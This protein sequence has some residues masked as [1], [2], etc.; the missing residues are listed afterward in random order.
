MSDTVIGDLFVRMGLDMTA[1]DKT[2]SSA[3]KKMDRFGT[4]MFFLGSRITA[5]V[6]VPITG[7]I[8]AVAKFGLDFDKAMSESVA[9]MG[10]VSDDLRAQME[11]TAKTVS[12]TT[13]FSSEEA[14]KGFY[15]LASAGLDAQTA[16][17]ALPV[18]A[19]FA[20]AGV[21]D[22]AK[23]TEFLAGAQASMST[24]FETSNQKVAD[25]AHIAD[26]LTAANN[27][28]LGTVQDFAEA[29]TTKAG[30]ALR[31]TNK[32]VEEGVAVLAVYAEQNIKGAAAGQQLW[33]VIRDL[34]VQAIK[35]AKAFHDAGIAVFDEYGNMRNLADIIG[36]VERATAKMSD[37]QKTQLMISLGIPARSQAAMKALIGY[38][39]AIRDNEAALKQAAGTTQEVADNQM[40]ALANQAAA[41]AHS[42]ENTAIDIFKSFIPV[43]QNYVIPLVKAAG[44][45]FKSFGRFIGELPEPVK[46]LGLAL[47]GVVAGIGPFVAFFGSMTL[48]TSVSMRGIGTLIGGLGELSKIIGFT[49]GVSLTLQRM[50]QIMPAEMAV[51]AAAAY[52]SAKAMGVRGF[53]LNRAATEAANFAGWEGKVTGSLLKQA[54]AQLVANGAVEGGLTMFGKMGIAAAALAGA[55]LLVQSYTHD[56]GE[57]AKWMLIPGYAQIQQLKDLINYLSTYD[58]VIGDVARILRDTFIIVL[59]ATEKELSKLSNAFH[60][61]FDALAPMAKAAFEAM[62]KAIIDELVEIVSAIPGAENIPMF[63][64]ML[65]ALPALKKSLHETANEMDRIAGFGTF[66][67]TTRP[68]IAALSSTLTGG[69]VPQPSVRVSGPTPFQFQSPTPPPTSFKGQGVEPPDPGKLTAVQR[70]AKDLADQ[71]TQN[72]KKLQELKLAWD[73]L[74]ETQKHDPEVLSAVWKSYDQLRQSTGAVVPELDKVFAAEED[75]QAVAAM[76]PE[77]YN[78]WAVVWSDAAVDMVD[79]AG[80]VYTALANIKDKASLD[81]FWKKNQ[82]SVQ[83]LLPFYDQL[84]PLMK[85]IVDRYQAWALGIQKASGALDAMKGKVSESVS[86]LVDVSAAKLA[87]L[88]DEIGLATKSGVDKEISTVRKGLH[89]QEVARDKSYNEQL[90]KIAAF[91]GD[92]TYVNAELAKLA[93]VKDTNEKISAADERLAAIRL[94][95]SLGVNKEIIKSFDNMTTQQIWDVDQQQAAWDKL[96]HTFTSWNNAIKNAGD[97]FSTLGLGDAAEALKGIGAGLDEVQQG[98]EAIYNADNLGATISGWI[99]LANGAVKAFKSVMDVGSKA[100]RVA[101]GA[102]TGAMIGTQIFPG[103]GTLIGAGV[104]ALI[105]AFSGDPAWK[106]LQQTVQ[107]HWNETISKTLANAISKDSE[108]LGGDVNAMLAHLADIADESGG[109]SASNVGQ[110]ATRLGKVFDQLATNQIS[111]S[112]AAEVLDNSFDALV[113]GGTQAN[114]MVSDQIVRLVQLEQ[115]YKTGSEAIKGFVDAQVSNL[116]DGFNKVVAAVAGPLVKAFDTAADGT[117]GL[118]GSVDRLY[119]KQLKLIAQIKDLQKKSSLTAQQEATLR[120][121]REDLLIV[122]AQLGKANG[123]WKD[124]QVLLGGQTQELQ[125]DFQNLGIIAV[126]AFQE[127]VDSGKSVV[128]T[129]TDMQSGLGTLNSMLND[130]GLDASQI[131]MLSDILGLNDFMKKNPGVLEGA[132]GLNQIMVS[133]HNLGGMNQGMFDALAGTAD[134]LFKDMT[135]G[136]LTANQAFMVMQPSLQTLWELEKKYGFTVDE[137]TQSLLDQAEAAGFVGENQMSANDK[138]IAGLDKIVGRLDLLLQHFGVDLPNDIDTARDHLKDFGDTDPSIDVTWRWRHDPNDPN[139]P[140]D[141]GDGPFEP[142]KMASGGV[143]TGPRSVIAGEAGPEAI[144]PLDR[145]FD[146]M[147]RMYGE[148]SHP[149]QQTPVV[150]NHYWEAVDED[151]VRRFV[152]R[153]EFQ[154]EFVNQAE[155]NTHD[156][157]TGIR[158]VTSRS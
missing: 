142:P 5:G 139:A 114:G 57:T 97:L 91:A 94:A 104:G 15:E 16:V 19:K 27:R 87:D 17:G 2:L 28:A 8:G 21:M 157:G 135:D 37:A 26:V 42:F 56:W 35:H 11:E 113:K 30:A 31:Q 40:K 20:Q 129:L 155:T 1:L 153:P 68:T 36:D 86:E 126:G 117:D 9:I 122:T 14:A 22:L 61:A 133:M 120:K 132:S 72:G 82:A 141:T 73:A 39:D 140:P 89:Q 123:D 43:I 58:G 18:T 41:L 12:T 13:K 34:S 60:D 67:G 150:H 76:M 112:H 93:V 107:Y 137:N 127:S 32:S 54:D 143:L 6:T 4:Q 74:S 128:D 33:M 124:A 154:N 100:G 125:T 90:K 55:I 144:I 77:L 69:L 47:L 98:A 62:K 79:H 109:I 84:D 96:Q 108:R 45:E 49:S 118:N 115:E 44:E 3:E 156:L 7:L 78:K 80:Q 138:M 88:Q 85:V 105:G 147:D 131:P 111:T 24:G 10:N 99:Q 83:E 53:Y 146:E 136:G 121:A 101:S 103:Y 145:L 149:S 92:P 50:M 48:L 134:K 65:A 116:V 46:A 23:A 63:A 64:G 81:A 25:M 151:S 102:M 110:W 66:T 71:W 38:S 119:G 95:I 152:R 70:A 51:E 29:L 158:N 52:D 59:D 148:G 75:Q 130:F 106:Q